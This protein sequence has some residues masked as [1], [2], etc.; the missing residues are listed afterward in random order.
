[1]DVR[2]KSTCTDM[3]SVE[4][5]WQARQWPSRQR[6]SIVLPERC[7]RLTIIMAFPDQER[8]S[9]QLESRP[10]PQKPTSKYTCTHS[11]SYATVSSPHPSFPRSRTACA[12][13]SSRR[14]PSL[15]NRD[16]CTAVVRRLYSRSLL[17]PIAGLGS[18]SF[19][20]VRSRRNALFRSNA[21][22]DP[23][24]SSTLVSDLR[25]R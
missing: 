12:A 21:H 14:T 3:F 9:D 15:S 5:T 20:P 7:E 16:V 10:E 4:V 24:M 11:P 23:L 22:E 25:K 17:L 6:M 19:T 18:A 13:S 1:M 2:G 8:F